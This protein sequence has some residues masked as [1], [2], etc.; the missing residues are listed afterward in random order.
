M[1]LGDVSRANEGV[2]VYPPTSGNRRKFGPLEIVIV[3]WICVHAR[4]NG[5]ACRWFPE[6]RRDGER[7]RGKKIAEDFVTGSRAGNSRAAITLIGISVRALMNTRENRHNVGIQKRAATATGRWPTWFNLI[8]GLMSDIMQP[9]VE[10][11]KKKR[12]HEYCRIRNCKR[13]L[14][15]YYYVLIIATRQSSGPS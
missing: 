7:S 12:N 14:T 8:A 5:R 2:G 9:V 13:I 11:S 15:V 1:V 10:R 4:N 3:K 6:D